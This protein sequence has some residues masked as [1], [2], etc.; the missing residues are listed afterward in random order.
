MEWEKF[1]KLNKFSICEYMGTL[2]FLVEKFS[3][4]W[5]A[6]SKT[7]PRLEEDTRSPILKS[8]WY[9]GGV[10]LMS[11]PTNSFDNR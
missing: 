11:E 10:E 6:F 4:G 8:T 7:P 5:G 1:D 3:D 2:F 9:A